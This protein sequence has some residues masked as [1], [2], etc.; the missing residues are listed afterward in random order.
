MFL[1]IR[2]RQAH[3]RA[4]AAEQAQARL[5]QDAEAGRALEAKMRAQAEYRE[6][7]GHK[8]SMAGLLMTQG[9][10]DQAEALVNEVESNPSFGAFYSV[11]GGV[12]GKRGE[13]RAAL[14]NFARII[15]FFPED[16]A[17]YHSF[18]PLLLQIGDVE[19]YQRHR[20]RI[21][22]HFANT[23]DPLI[24]E[25]LAKDCLLLPTSATN[26]ALIA[27][28]ADVAVAA[29]PSHKSWAYFEFVKG[30]SE[31]RQG[32]FGKAADWLEKV[33]REEG[34]WNR[35]VASYMV[36]AMAQY[37]VNPEQARTTLANGLQTAD[38]H[39]P[40]IGDSLGEDWNDWI[41]ANLLKREA[42][43]LI[44]GNAK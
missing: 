44:K 35:R 9:K 26:L 34:H 27:R 43:G 36:L 31:Y 42:T 5:R 37:R 4:L 39:L 18:A 20:E 32:N 12:H 16:Y 1:F 8:I 29:G 30:F 3:Q 28:M 14:T 41:I 23:S 40:A 17:A 21:L 13:W 11:F 25:R 2:E 24:A 19:G 22:S 38:K 10:H 33:L 15:E 6:K 7:M